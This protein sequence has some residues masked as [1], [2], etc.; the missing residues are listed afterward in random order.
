LDE[1]DPAEEVAVLEA[2][3]QNVRGVRAGTPI[4]RRR[5]HIRVAHV[6]SAPVV[7]LTGE[8]DLDTV[9]ELRRCLDALDGRVVVDL[10][11]VPFLDSSGLGAIAGAR[12]RLR[13]NDGDLRL[14]SPQDQVRGVLEIMG[15]DDWIIGQPARAD[16]GPAA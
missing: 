13:A 2:P 3:G 8:I 5:L 15:V 6:A 4:T 16:S 1:G 14:R 9:G 11:A 12:K 10:Y 7:I